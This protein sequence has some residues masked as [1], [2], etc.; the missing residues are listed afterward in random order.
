MMRV[1]AIGSKAKQLES[2][3]AT[4]VTASS[5]AKKIRGSLIAGSDKIYSDRES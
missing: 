2:I 3:M 5:L 1:E 4:D